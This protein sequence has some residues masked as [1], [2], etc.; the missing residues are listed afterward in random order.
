MKSRIELLWLIPLSI[1]VVA[2]SFVIMFSG[3]MLGIV[4][5]PFGF[6]FRRTHHFTMGGS[7]AACPRLTLSKFTVIKHPEFDPERRAVYAQNHVSMLDGHLACMVVPHAFCGLQL[8]WHFKIPAYGWIMKLTNGIPVYPHKDGRT[9]E[10]TEAARDRIYNRKISILAFPEGHRTRDGKVGEFKRGVF[11]MARDAGAP[12]IPLAVRGIYDV[13]KRK[14]LLFRPGHVQ[15]YLGKP[16]ETEG[17][18]DDEARQMAVDTQKIIAD[19]ADHGI[20]PEGVAQ[21]QAQASKAAA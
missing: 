10:I 19:F 12:I 16:M 1:F 17:L 15:I 5:L 8:A 13:N 18:S 21:A 20:L 2:G 14:S 4:L 11:F 9:A 6:D 3:V 7:L